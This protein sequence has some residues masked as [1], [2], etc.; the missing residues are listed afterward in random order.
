MNKKR[1]ALLFTTA[2][3]AVGCLFVVSSCDGGGST[4]TS[5][6]PSTSTS[7]TS[8][9]LT[10]TPTTANINIDETIV[11]TATVSDSST[12]LVSWTSSDN[13]VASV[14]NGTVTGVSA[15][16]AT[17]TASA[18]KKGTTTVLETKTCAVTVVDEKITLS[19]STARI[20]LNESTTL[21]LE[22][23][24]N[25]E[26]TIVWSSSNESVATVSS[27]GVVTGIAA[28]STTIKASIGDVYASCEVTVY[29]SYFSLE[30]Q[31]SVVV[32]AT[33]AI[34][35]TGTV[36]GTQEW[37]SSDKTIATVDSTGHVTGVAQG[38]SV[39]TLSANGLTST[40][41][42][43]VTTTDDAAVELKSGNKATAVND[44]MNWYYLLESDTATV[45][46]IPTIA[47]DL[48]NIDITH[49][50]PSGANYVYLRYQPDTTGNIEYDVT[51]YV[52]SATDSTIAINGVDT[53]FT[54]GLNKNVSTFTSVPSTESA[55][56]FQFKFRTAGQYYIMPIFTATGAAKPA[57]PNALPGGT[58]AT[59]AVV[60]ANPGKW[61]YYLQNGG[62]VS[63]TP[64]MV[65]GLITVK[66]SV[67]EVT[68]ENV[69]NLVY[70][71]YQ[72]DS[73]GAV[74]YAV[75]LNINIADACKVEINGTSHDLVAGDNTITLD[76]TSVAPASSSPFQIKFLAAGD[77]SLKPAF[78][79]TSE[80]T[81]TPTPSGTDLPS[82][83]KNSVVAA[84]PLKWYYFSDGACVVDSATISAENEINLAISNIDTT[85]KKYVYIRYQ[86]DSTGGVT[87]TVKYSI[88]A[89]AAATVEIAGTATDLIAG[90]NTGSV[91][92]TSSDTATAKPFAVKF[93]TAA[94][95]ALTFAFLAA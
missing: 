79:S 22:A 16:S 4:T 74:D 75:T 23:S 17:I 71:R 55:S 94:T 61:Y 89:S 62:T 70:L 45:S 30:E 63:E 93:K 85:A 1:K 3:M 31:T 42:V 69:E 78:A 2:M 67:S 91:S 15:G 33:K 20:I 29:D 44:P 21:T 68:A 87:Y 37:T 39:I 65:D 56:P 26:G 36:S 18:R 83:G 25:F 32:G 6:E 9:G 92:F 27:S 77:Y 10:L 40:C 38:M 58:N 35:V 54:A 34:S 81:P 86:P 73:T 19:Q 72:P 49:T 46:S 76:Y 51:L 7:S 43:A 24:A 88:N 28:G 66:A 60:A 48:I 14:S 64:T 41:V 47:N 95:F 8:A 11:L 84:D 59:K 90:D 5:E 80:P 50:G 52:Y 53:A 57:D 13:A 82:G 12:Y